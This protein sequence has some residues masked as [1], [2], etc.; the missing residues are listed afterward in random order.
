MTKY[1]KSMFTQMANITARLQ[2]DWYDRCH[3]LPHLSW[4]SRNMLEMKYRRLKYRFEDSF[5]A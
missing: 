4:L 1:Q 2:S 3:G 5:K